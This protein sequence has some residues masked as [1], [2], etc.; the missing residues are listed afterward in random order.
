MACV[1][2]KQS[3]ATYIDGN[4]YNTVSQPVELP[5]TSLN[6]NPIK[7]FKTRITRPLSSA[8]YHAIFTD[9]VLP[10]SN[11]LIKGTTKS[12]SNLQT[13]SKTPVDLQITLQASKS[14][15]L[16][17]NQPIGFDI[18]F[19][20]TKSSNFLTYVSI[21]S[22]ELAILVGQSMT[23][24]EFPVSGKKSLNFTSV[25]LTY[26]K[27]V[28][29]KQLDI[30]VNSKLTFEALNALE[31][32]V[33]KVEASTRVIVSLSVSGGAPYTCLVNF[34]DN[35]NASF[36][37][38]ADRLT[39]KDLTHEYRFS[40]IF[41]V[42]V[43]CQSGQVNDS[44]LTDSQ[45]VYASNKPTQSDFNNFNQIFLERV[46]NGSVELELPFQTCS[47]GLVL[48]VID[49][50]T[51]TVIEEWICSDNQPLSTLGNMIVRLKVN[52]MPATFENYVSVRYTEYIQVASYLISWQDRIVSPPQIRVLTENPLLDQPVDFEVTVAVHADSMVRVDFGD[53][54]ANTI[55][56]QIN[57][58]VSGE[59]E[60]LHV[61]TLRHV[62]T[63]RDDGLKLQKFSFSVEQA[64]HLSRQIAGVELSF[65]LALSSFE[66]TVSKNKLDEVNQEPV[67][68]KIGK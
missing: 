5:F 59:E 35:T 64:N 60:K 47:Q 9:Q 41:N 18:T 46:N 31:L 62:Y 22:Q 45:I 15:Y 68:F 34:G 28:I 25:S 58:E 13:L 66:L 23:F 44:V 21:D 30:D 53:S 4:L 42:S 24:T 7:S 6:Y 54:E 1:W 17:V 19:L 57:G 50:V 65:E 29:T 26:P 56:Y 20:N 40:G 55:L 10:A 8:V 16:Q 48:Q 2:N 67:L 37:S 27:Q 11:V 39:R 33:T 38:L 12:V 36:Q 52:Q 32:T 61:F 14:G 43:K 49:Q 63:K 51:Q 3:L